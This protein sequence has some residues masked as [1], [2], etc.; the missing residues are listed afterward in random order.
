[1]EEKNVT[2]VPTREEFR[3][4]FAQAAQDWVFSRMFMAA[5]VA[6]LER[7]AQSRTEFAGAFMARYA[8]VENFL[9]DL[10]DELADVKASKAG[11]DLRKDSK[12]TIFNLDDE[13]NAAFVSTLETA[14][15]GIRARGLHADPACAVVLF[16]GV[17]RIDKIC[18]SLNEQFDRLIASRDPAASLRPA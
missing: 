2:A 1:M 9:R 8:T 12:G 5:P 16:E 14:L 11:V 4:A 6:A 3:A 18:A 13:E 10:T 15:V 7:S 17:M